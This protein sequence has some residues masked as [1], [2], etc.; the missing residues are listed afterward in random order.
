MKSL[1]RQQ[2]INAYLMYITVGILLVIASLSIAGAAFGVFRT[3]PSDRTAHI[4][5]ILPEHMPEVGGQVAVTYENP[6]SDAI[7]EMIAQGYIVEAIVND[8][9][10]DQSIVIYKRVR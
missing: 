7:N 9:L 2:K 5:P 3:H 6:T 10:E 4:K 8:T 1:E